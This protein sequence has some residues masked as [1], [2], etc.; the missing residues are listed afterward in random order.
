[1]A[2][3]NKDMTLKEIQFLIKHIEKGSLKD[4][5]DI[6]S[7]E[8]KKENSRRLV[9]KL[10][11]E[12]GELAENIRKNL[13]YNGE[14]IKGTIEEELFDIFYYII[15]IANDYNIDLEEIFHIKDKINKEKYERSFSL[16]EAR[17]EYEKNTK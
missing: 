5:E 3:N 13:R 1:M 7:E 10:I 6:R 2:E 17:K 12:F 16:E 14:N 9:L 11:E 4:I 8:E 15:A